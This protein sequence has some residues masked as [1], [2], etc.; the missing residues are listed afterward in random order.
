ML[1]VFDRAGSS[2]DLRL[3]PA[4]VLPSACLYGVGI[5]ELVISRLNGWPV[6]FPC[7][8]LELRLAA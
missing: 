8:R 6:G 7:Q 2:A 1:R 3:T 4:A 5:P